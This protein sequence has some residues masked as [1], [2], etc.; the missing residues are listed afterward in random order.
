MRIKESRFASDVRALL[1]LVSCRRFLVDG[2]KQVE[3]YKSRT[4]YMKRKNG[5]NEETT[6][7]CEN[8][9]PSDF[10]PLVLLFES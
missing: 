10:L 7:G 1:A 9:I 2:G 5:N 4:T 8:K 3:V 6:K